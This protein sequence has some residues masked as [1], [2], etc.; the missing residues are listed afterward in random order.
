[1]LLSN[2][3]APLF[4]PG[5]PNSN[6]GIDGM[7]IDPENPEAA[8]VVSDWTKLRSQLS[9]AQRA[10]VIKLLGRIGLWHVKSTALKICNDGLAAKAREAA[11]Q[12]KHEAP[13][14]NFGAYFIF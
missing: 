12:R 4:V 13:S 2:F 7:Y 11:G 3:A 6:L 8:R 14:L 9:D 10:P 1:M 5:G